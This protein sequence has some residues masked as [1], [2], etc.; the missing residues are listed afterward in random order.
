MAELA[1]QDLL[2][3]IL[4]MTTS[5]NDGQALVAIRKANKLLA[6]AGWTWERLIAGKIT[7]V[8]DPFNGVGDP[9]ANMFNAAPARTST[10]A[11]KASKSTSSNPPPAQNIP[12]TAT[13]S[14]PI[15]TMKNKYVGFCYCCGDETPAG[16]G[17]F[18]TPS[19]RN[20]A[21]PS[22]SHVVCVPCNTSG[23]I[24]ANPT[25]MRRRTRGKA[26]ISDLV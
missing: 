11:P 17:F 14:S 15:S 5:D 22:K 9:F 3:K 24:Y 10:P 16:A 25:G 12:W 23:T 21:A 26:N 20:P 2:V 1:K 8:Q 7:I 19:Y 6:D 18:F 13:P 4:G